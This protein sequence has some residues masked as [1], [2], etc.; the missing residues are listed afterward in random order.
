MFCSQHLILSSLSRDTEAVAHK[1]VKKDVCLKLSEVDEGIHERHVCDDSKSPYDSASLFLPGGTLGSFLR[2]V[3]HDSADARSARA[4]LLT[5]EH[6]SQGK[7]L[8]A[9]NRELRRLALR[10]DA[11]IFTCALSCHSSEREASRGR[12]EPSEEEAEEGFS[13]KELDLLENERMGRVVPEWE[14]YCCWKRR[15]ARR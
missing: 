4:L 14:A 10:H 8:S 2:P 1:Q 12:R 6:D 15:T 11:G 7:C 5:T 3:V 9:A 13:L